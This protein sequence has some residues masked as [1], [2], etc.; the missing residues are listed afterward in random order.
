MRGATWLMMLLVRSRASERERRQWSNGDMQHW[1]M[2]NGAAVAPADALRW[3]TDC[4]ERPMSVR[5]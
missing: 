2:E 1:N 3:I 4:D 5:G